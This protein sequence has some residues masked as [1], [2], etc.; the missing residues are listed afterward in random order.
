MLVINSHVFFF[1]KPKKKAKDT[2]E[3]SLTSNRGPASELQCSGQVEQGKDNQAN[4]SPDDLADAT[5][6]QGIETDGPCKQMGAH[7]EDL[8]QN[9]GPSKDFLEQRTHANRLANDLDGVTKV[10]DVGVFFSE[11][12]EHEAGPGGEA[13]HDEDEDDTGDEADGSDDLGQG[14]NTQRDCF[15]DENDA[16][17]PRGREVLAV[18]TGAGVTAGWSRGGHAPPDAWGCACAGNTAKI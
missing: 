1:F 10:F 14:K 5:A 18:G 12:A 16:T 17:L 15:G 13:T 3:I 9:L 8:E 7:D 6:T 4:H 2:D 11:L